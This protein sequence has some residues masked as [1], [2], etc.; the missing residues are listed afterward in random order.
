MKKTTT[1]MVATLGLVMVV[2]AGCSSKPAS[3]V[4]L[5][6]LTKSFEAHATKAKEGQ[7]FDAAGFEAQVNDKTKKIYS[8]KDKLDVELL[9]SGEVVGFKDKNSND[10]Y[11]KA[12][13]EQIF[14]LQVE[15]DKKEV[16]ATDEHKHHYRHR[17]GGG[18]FT[19]YLIGSMLSRQRGHYGGR[20]WSAPS[21][22]R[23]VKP[24]YYGKSVR[25]GSRTSTRRS[26]RSGGFGFG[27]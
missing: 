18:F 1:W 16:V 15:K 2:G 24:G 12:T 21:S 13:D 11:E 26:S 5:E 10:T 14:S 19:G 23:Y 8:G 25:S 9:K 7:D 20:Y 27:K 22:A 17:P 4:N 3:Q 6:A